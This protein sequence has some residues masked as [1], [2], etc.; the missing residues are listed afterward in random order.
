MSRLVKNTFIYTL[1]N[2]IPQAVNFLLLPIYTRFLSPNDYGIVSSMTILITILAIVFTLCLERSI[3]RL[4]FD[5]KDEQGKRDYLGTIVVS[6]I[7]NS[8]ICMLLIFAFRNI[9]G[10]IFS[11]I[12]F[13]PFYVYAVLTCF[14][15]V[16]GY[17]PMIVFQVK[18]KAGSF[19]ALVLSK[20]FLMVLLNIWFVCFLRAGAA[21]QLQAGLLANLF[22]LPVNLYIVA[23]VINFHFA[24]DILK[25]SLAFSLPMV[26]SLVTAWILDM[27]NQVFIAKYLSMADVGIYSLGLKMALVGLIV[28]SG[29]DSAYSPYFFRLANEDDQANSKVTLQKVNNKYAMMLLLLAFSIAFFSR[30]AVILMGPKYA[31]S[32]VITRIVAFAYLFSGLG[33]LASRS[34]LQEKRVIEN[35][36]IS[37]G[38][39]ALSIILNI[40]LIPRIGIYGAALSSLLTFIVGF[41]IQYQYSRYCYFIPLNFRRLGAYLLTAVVILVVYH[42]YIEQFLW[43]SIAS[44]FIIFSLI[45]WFYAVRVIGIKNLASMNLNRFI[46]DSAEKG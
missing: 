22:F 31:R 33:G 23:R 4:Y 35:M 46:F 8:L 36:F 26:P 13:Y 16:I 14:F 38:S 34:I 30:E 19:I 32:Y 1:G 29:F 43:Q 2:I 42:F 39:A 12:P 9:F 45:I 11:A 15:M 7:I 3:F 20:F 27:S 40:M 41:V 10:K 5:Y 28:V 37:I 6:I 25:N 44:K 17:P 21:G 18:E 24:F